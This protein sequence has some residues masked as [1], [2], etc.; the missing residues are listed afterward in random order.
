MNDVFIS[1]SRQD[2]DFVRKLYNRLSEDQREAWV[3]WDNI[4][5]TADWLDEI[6]AG[7][8]GADSFIYVISPDSVHSEVCAIELQ[9]AL[10]YNKR[11]IPVMRRELIEPHDR[12]A[13]HPMIS[14]HNWLFFRED[15]D[16]DVA[17]TSLMAA[18]DSDLEHMKTH[19]RL[20]VRAK[21][22]R[23]R[24][25]DGSLLLR[26]TDLREAEV[27][28]TNSISKKPEPT[29]L[30]TEFIMFSHNV[31]SSRQRSLLIWV[32]AGLAMALGL[33]ALSFVLYQD[34]NNQRSIAEAERL[35]ADR[36]A[37][38][39]QSLAL[40]S[41]AEQIP[42]RTLALALALASSN[43]ENP[44][45]QV[46]RALAGVVYAP[47]VR[48]ILRGH[49]NVVH[50]VVVSPD[51]NYIASVS[52]DATIILWD[53]NTYEMIHRLGL[54]GNEDPAIGHTQAIRSASFHPDG[55]RLF[56]AGADGLV[57]E[58]DIQSG[59]LLRVHD[60]HDATVN[61]LVIH[62]DG[63]L[64]ATGDEDGFILLWDLVDGSKRVLSHRE[65]G[66]PVIGNRAVRAVAFHPEINQLASGHADG[67]LVL[68]S[69]NNEQR[70]VFF[71]LPAHDGAITHLEFNLDGTRIV[72][73]S[74]DET[75]RIWQT[76][77][78]LLDVE[79]AGHTNQVMYATFSPDSQQLI[80]TSHDRTIIYWQA[81]NGRQLGR[82]WAH[83]DWVTGAS[84]ITDGRAV[85]ASNDT[86]L[87]LWDLVPGNIVY[88]RLAHEDWI[89]V[90]DVS[91]DGRL[92]L[93]GA[94]DTTIKLW[95]LVTG[96]EIDLFEGHT[97]G[98]RG[99]AFTPD[100]TQFL[101][102]SADGEL[103]LWSIED[104]D[105]IS[106]RL[107]D[108]GGLN[109]VAISPDGQYALVASSDGNLLYITLED[110]VIV[111]VLE[112]HSRSALAVN[113]NHDG[114]RALSG[115]LDNTVILW[116]LTT[117]E[118]IH[119]ME[120]HTREALSVAFSPDGTRAVSGSRDAGVI[121]W[122]LETGEPIRLLQGHG[123]S[124]R[125][126]A[127]APQGNM[128]LSAAADLT[129]FLWDLETGDILRQMNGHER[130]VYDVAFTP[131]GRYAFSGSRDKTVILWRIDDQQDLITWL[132]DNRYLRPLTEL[133]C[134]IYNVDCFIFEDVDFDEEMG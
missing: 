80:T 88:Q 119:R 98:I 39:A 4:P 111:S 15:D 126:I 52:N 94:D 100:S 108:V 56:S 41:I 25:R 10:E 42:D 43:I 132:N 37:E 125:G 93:S 97:T 134:E 21:E 29:E 18:L 55:G 32:T 103:R 90:V 48:A 124:V 14:S 85:T 86:S 20:L 17:Y 84:F 113:F 104:G 71:N 58:W 9:H 127:Y 102:G 49:E 74:A 96:E 112:G 51:G 121:Y 73:S 24:N 131:D 1:Y 53:A 129:L 77:T 107:E 82:Y 101:S 13:L 122:N 61:H 109:D 35:N 66:Q 75:A 62:P 7:I 115:S 34:A 79:L 117:G 91:S 30:H 89:Q 27:W 40:A 36:R 65:D 83:S 67:R 87:I 60:A 114:S 130:V 8:E 95:D 28:L 6:K 50:R 11:L 81:S 47:G 72:T 44:P 38:I 22:W 46:E 5:L 12:A 106:F 110:Q 64:M 105:F 3:D 70:P 26:G 2:S 57:I 118:V 16:F 63:E 92:A 123:S 31:S 133:E 33:A 69:F 78:G 99:L 54:V 120:G 128:A 19:T 116:D 23:E 45:S 76:R 68:W 59:Q